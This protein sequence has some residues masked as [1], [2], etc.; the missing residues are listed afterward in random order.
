MTVALDHLL[1]DL[2][3]RDV[4]QSPGEQEERERGRPGPEKGAQVVYAAIY[5]GIPD[6]ADDIGQRIKLYY[7]CLDPADR[8]RSVDYRR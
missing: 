6:P 1:D 3:F 4:K 2:L 8:A 7:L 5:D